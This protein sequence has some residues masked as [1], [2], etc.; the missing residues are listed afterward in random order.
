M[1]LFPSLERLGTR[2]PKK[3]RNHFAAIDRGHRAAGVIE[4][5]DRGIDAQHVIDRGVQIAAFDGAVLGY[6]TQAI[7]AAD[8]PAPLD[9]AAA[10]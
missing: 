9:A 2:L 6:F 7:G 1:R 4:E 10:H 3:F 8:D 5:A